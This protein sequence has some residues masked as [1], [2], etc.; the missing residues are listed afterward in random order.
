MYTQRWLLKGCL[1][2]ALACA[3]G[4]R[5]KGPPAGRQQAAAARTSAIE[6]V[7]V[8]TLENHDARQIYGNHEH[9]PYLNKTLLPKYAHAAN[10]VDLL[11]LHIPSEPHY[12]MMEA[13]TNAFADHTFT[14]DSDPSAENSTSETAHLVTQI[15]N[16]SNG[17]TWRSYQEGLN[18]ATGLCP[19]HSRGF[20]AAKHD[21]F[22]FFQDVAGNPPAADNAYCIAHHRPYDALATDLQKD[23][24]ASYTF[25]TP[26]VC[27][28]MH[29]ATDCH[30]SNAILAGDTWLSTEL[31]RLIDYANKRAGVIFIVW[32][33]GSSELTMPF[34]AVGPGVKSGYASPVKLTHNSIIKSVESILGLP[35]LAS[36]QSDNSLSDLFRP[37]SYP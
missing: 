20:Y 19:I 28:D 35:M 9:A 21:P 5:E 37:G 34:V 7:F 16:A 24:V 25:I 1:W 4:C 3:T 31:P 26:D 2:S 13:G 8:I 22:V 11:A 27:H 12:V 30:E 10:F 29:G 32:D 18:A 17:V 36:V 15:K 23:D 6:H 14:T 33:E